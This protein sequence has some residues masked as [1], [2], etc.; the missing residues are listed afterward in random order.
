[1]RPVMTDAT[2]ASLSKGVSRSKNAA[3]STQARAAYPPQPH[4]HVSYLSA[5][6]WMDENARGAGRDS[7]VEVA[8]AVVGH[9]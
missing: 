7:G 9:R 8:A 3:Q 2:E 4:V 1:M 5:T 6:A